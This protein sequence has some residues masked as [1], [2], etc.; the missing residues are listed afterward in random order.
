[1]IETD[2]AFTPVVELARLVR[3]RAVSPVD[4]VKTYLE[5]I[6]RWESTLH[7]YV[8]VAGDSALRQA[9]DA[10]AAVMRGEKRGAMHGIPIAEK[11]QFLT[12]GIRTMLGTRT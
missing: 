3:E 2:L 11:D 7:A 4:L 1:M 8:T 10:E 12:K 9:K 5:R 6:D